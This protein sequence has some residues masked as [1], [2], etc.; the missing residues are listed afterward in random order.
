[1]LKEYSKNESCQHPSMVQEFAYGS[2]TGNFICIH[3]EC[4]LPPSILGEQLRTI[5]SV[6]LKKADLNFNLSI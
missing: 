5:H 6:P 3:C 2:L 4:L 1:M